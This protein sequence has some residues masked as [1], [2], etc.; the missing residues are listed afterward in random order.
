[1]SFGITN[2]VSTYLGTPNAQH[3]NSIQWNSRWVVWA[4]EMIGMHKKERV[5]VMHLKTMRG[6]IDDYGNSR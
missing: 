2:A 1:M 3:I 6:Y 5:G 4:I